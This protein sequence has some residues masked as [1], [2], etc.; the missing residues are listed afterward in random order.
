MKRLL[1]CLL[2]LFIALSISCRLVELG[3]SG[4]EDVEPVDQ[5]EGDSH[6]EEEDVDEHIP[7]WNCALP[8]KLHSLQI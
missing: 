7:N 5:D 3:S 1:Y 6:D 4:Q 8:R 2:I